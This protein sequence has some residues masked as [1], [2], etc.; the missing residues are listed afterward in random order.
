MGTGW[1]GKWKSFCAFLK[2]LLILNARILIETNEKPEKF[3]GI[4]EKICRTKSSE[5]P[6]FLTLPTIN[7]ETS[8]SIKYNDSFPLIFSVSQTFPLIFL[9]FLGFQKAL[10]VAAEKLQNR[11]RRRNQKKKRNQRNPMPRRLKARLRRAEKKLRRRRRRKL[12]S[13]R[14]IR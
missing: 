11:Q 13:H 1:M 5:F 12:E 14:R 9:F 2:L 6:R 10:V 8:C 7:R 4:A 3:D